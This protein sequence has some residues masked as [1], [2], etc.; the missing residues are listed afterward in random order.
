MH[1]NRSLMVRERRLMSARVTPPFLDGRRSCARARAA[2][3]V[4]CS[5]AALEAVLLSGSKDEEEERSASLGGPRE[6]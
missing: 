4:C 5:V 2:A 1:D 3:I 6:R